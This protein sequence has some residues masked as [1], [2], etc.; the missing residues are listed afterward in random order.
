[1]FNRVQQCLPRDL[2]RDFWVSKKSEMKAVEKKFLLSEERK[3]KADNYYDEE[4]K[5][6]KRNMPATVLRTRSPL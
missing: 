1:M 4:K 3:Y 6:M 5:L 2:I